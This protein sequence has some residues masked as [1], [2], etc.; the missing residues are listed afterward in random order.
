[1]ER[2]IGAPGP[3]SLPWACASARRIPAALLLFPLFFFF[4]LTN[5]VSDLVK[6]ALQLLVLLLQLFDA[7]EHFTSRLN[8]HASYSFRVLNLN[9]SPFCVVFQGFVFDFLGPVQVV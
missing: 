2:G 8:S 3:L 9:V 1:A 4:L 6:L 5:N 7:F